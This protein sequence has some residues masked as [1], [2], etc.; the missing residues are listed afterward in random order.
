MQHFKPVIS[1]DASLSGNS[2]PVVASHR[3]A[4]SKSGWS[5]LS[6]TVDVES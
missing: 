3:L 6:V 1:N 2:F 5:S 4:G